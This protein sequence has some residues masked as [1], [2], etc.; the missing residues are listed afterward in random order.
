MGSPPALRNHVAHE[1]NNVNCM[2]SLLT[3]QPEMN[4]RISSH[5]CEVLQ[6]RARVD[7]R[8]ALTAIMRVRS[9]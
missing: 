5:G 9:G 2:T 6:E 3:Y 4:I 1:S 8:A 7:E